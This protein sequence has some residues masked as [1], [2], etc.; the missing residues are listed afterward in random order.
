MQDMHVSPLTLTLVLI[1]S[2]NLSTPNRSVTPSRGIPNS[3]SI[4][5]S[6]IIPALGMP[7]V[8]IEATVAVRFISIKSL[9][10]KSIP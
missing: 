4:N 2:S 1:I 9:N 5:D 3:V 6:I 7:G 8:Q 10:T